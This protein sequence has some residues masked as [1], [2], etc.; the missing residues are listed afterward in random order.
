MFSDSGPEQGSEEWQMFF[1][2]AFVS[3]SS[4][5]KL[6]IF[7]K[8]YVEGTGGSFALLFAS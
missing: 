8:H 4:S 7:E 3:W 1:D 6:E 5:L 2:H